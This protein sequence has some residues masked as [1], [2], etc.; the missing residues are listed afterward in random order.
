[1]GE[2]VQLFINTF[3]ASLRR[4]GEAFDIRAGDKRLT[5]SARKVRAILATTAV[6]LSTDAIALAVEHNIDIVLLNRSG[7]PYGRFWHA[8]MG[9]TAAIRRAQVDAADS[10][11][12]LETVRAWTVAKLE[13][14]ASFLAELGRRRPAQ[15]QRF[16]AAIDRINAARDALA[17]LTG[18]VHEQRATILGHEGAAGA[19]YWG[20]LGELPPQAFRFDHRSKHPARDPFNAMLNYAYG[21]LYSEV[22]RACI[23]AGLDP[24]VGLLHTDN[25]NK[26][27][28][29]F[30]LIEPFR[31]WADRVV[32]TLFTGRRCSV[33]MFRQTDDGTLL[34]K[35][36]KELLLP[37]LTEHLDAAVRY[38]IKNPGGRKRTRQIKHS[39]I[40]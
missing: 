5:L 12:G 34:D 36:G 8:K 21:V 38:S 20:L 13:N 22:D 3:G 25:Y 23:I 31:I 32:V 14:Q 35:P 28:L 11:S 26:R 40:G 24:F 30:D 27:S 19:A 10:A 16:E 17:N 1:M 15:T 4:T 6:H 29:T 37:A 9:S 33:D 7:R 18:S 39:G 2:R